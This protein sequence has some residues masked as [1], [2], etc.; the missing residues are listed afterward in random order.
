MSKKKNFVPKIGMHLYVATDVKR[1]FKTACAKN[2]GNMS[3]TLVAL[4]KYYVKNGM[5]K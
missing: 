5:P 2:G 4:M 3:T 1:L